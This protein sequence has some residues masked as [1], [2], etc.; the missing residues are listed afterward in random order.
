MKKFFAIAF[1][2]ASL[3]ACGGGEKTEETPAADTTA[4][5]PVET[6]APAVDTTAKVDTAAP[7]AAPAE[8]PK[9]EEKK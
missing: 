9:A 4:T 7:A 6:P 2:A 1:I 5:A 3:V 8:A